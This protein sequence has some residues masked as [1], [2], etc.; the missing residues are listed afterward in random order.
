MINNQLRK[1]K[2]GFEAFFNNKKYNN[3]LTNIVQKIH[4]A[5]KVLVL[6]NGGSCTIATHFSEDLAKMLHIPSFVFNDAALITCLS[7]DYSYEDAMKEWLEIYYPNSILT[8][9]SDKALV[10]LISSSGESKNV[11]NAAKYIP[12]KNNIITLTGFKS[13]NTLS[14]LG[15]IN[16]HIPI[17]DYGICESIHATFLHIILDELIDS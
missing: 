1:Y 5:N 10:I 8:G 6:G 15:N 2:F 11:I 7:N 12:N 3:D 17:N 4:D 14:Q 13:N 16:V 9:V